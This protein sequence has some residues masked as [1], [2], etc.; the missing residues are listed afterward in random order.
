[1]KQSQ[2]H[3]ARE[4]YMAG[5]FRDAERTLHEILEEDPNHAEARQW[6]A[7]TQYAMRRLREAKA[8]AYRAL[9]INPELAM[10]H[11]VLGWCHVLEGKRLAE[12]EKEFRTAVNLDPDL[13]WAHTSLGWLYARQG[14][15]A[16]AEAELRKAIELDTSGSAAYENL[17]YVYLRQKQ[18]R[19]AIT[20]LLQAKDINP[21]NPISHMNL[22]AA[23]SHERRFREAFEQYRLAF[24]LKPSVTAFVGLFSSWIASHRTLLVLAVVSL[25]VIGML[26]H[27]LS[28][29]PFIVAV[30]AYFAI[31]GLA[32]LRGGHWTWAML[33]FLVVLLVIALYAWLLASGP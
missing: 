1:M 3:E 29:L 4:F 26:M 30:V 24:G 14:R 5:R 33:H 19:D 17:G 10:P 18:S 21:Q 32:M 28:A 12:A 22:A 7:R 23:Y 27:S 6:L 9:E 13:A 11:A 16:E 8:E 15:Y 2:V 20:M 31:G 25:Y